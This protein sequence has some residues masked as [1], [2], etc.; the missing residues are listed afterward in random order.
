VSPQDFVEEGSMGQLGQRVGLVLG[1]MFAMGLQWIGRPEGLSIEAWYVVSLSVLM[2]VWWVTEAI[3]IAATALL[4]LAVLPLMG[5]SS[6]KDAAAPYADPI[7]FMFN[8]GI[9]LAARY[10]VVVGRATGVSGGLFHAGFGR[11]FHV[12]FQHGHHADAGADRAGC[13]TGVRS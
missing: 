1:L 3:P 10:C 9:M 2:V 5:V 12:D 4:P 11:Y 6:T 13:C 7:I 8:G